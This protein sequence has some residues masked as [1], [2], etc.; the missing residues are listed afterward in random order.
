LVPL[1]LTKQNLILEQTMIEQLSAHGV[2]P[3]DLSPSL[4]KF[5][6]VKN[7]LARKDTESTITNES[8]VSLQP[9]SNR[10]SHESLH[11][12]NPEKFH[13]QETVDID[14]RWTLL[15]DLFLVLISDSVYDAR[16]RT[17][18]ECFGNCLEVSKLEII[19]FEEKV[20]NALEIEEASEQTWKET[21]IM[22][23]RRKKALRKKYMY[24][25][26]ATIGGGLVLGLSAGLLAPVIGAGLAA[27]F[28]T[29]GITGTSGFL[30]G[31]GGAAIVT[32]AGTA[33]GAKIGSSGMANR[34]DH[35]KTFEFRPLHNHKRV[36]L[37]IT[38]SGWMLGKED[39]VRLPFSTVDPI[40]GDL[41]SLY[42]EP[43]MLRSMGQTINIL[44]TEVLTQ[45][46]QQ[47]L[48]A[49]ILMALMSS[50]QLPMALSK[51]SYLLDN[52]WNVS[53]DR[54][55][56]SGLIL[57]DTLIKRNLGVRPVTLV[58]FSLGARVIYSCLVELAKKNA[59]GLIQDVFIFGAPVVVKSDQF[60][61]ARTVVHGRF[62]NGYS[63]KDWILGYLFRAT[64]GG[65]GRVAGLAPVAN[66]YGLE[67]F[68][69]TEFVDGH[70]GYRKAMPTLLSQLGWEVLSE[71]FA[72]IEDPDP[73]QHRVRQRQLIEEFDLARK[74]MEEE[75]KKEKKKKSFFGW[76]KKE[77]NWW[78]MYDKELEST[79]KAD[80][81]TPSAGLGGP[82]SSSSSVANADGVLFDVD[83]IKNELVDIV[84][85][86]NVP[87][88]QFEEYVPTQVANQPRK[89]ESDSIE[90]SFDPF[91]DDETERRGGTVAPNQPA[92]SRSSIDSRL[93]DSSS[94]VKAPQPLMSTRRGRP[95]V[96][97]AL[98]PSGSTPALVS[99]REPR[100]TV[101]SSST[102]NL[103]ST[104]LPLASPPTT[105]QVSLPLTMHPSNHNL[106][107]SPASTTSLP[108]IRTL[109]STPKRLSFT[110][111]RSSPSSFS[112]P[113]FDANTIG[114]Y[115]TRA[116]NETTQMATN[117][118]NSATT[119]K[120]IKP[121]GSN[122]TTTSSDGV[123]MTFEDDF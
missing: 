29:I 61:L 76:K 35:V 86:D 42:W 39:D 16:S 80:G 27:G 92:A 70:M 3:S 44:A 94:V 120:D 56:A 75:A 37:I 32:T 21:D 81:P 113:K 1:D 59:Y 109:P 34:M 15:C 66:V 58:G 9:S 51:L 119:R 110:H 106:S 93:S 55:W 57:A 102:T 13:N 121:A 85:S 53:L 41:Y 97:P 7:P 26:M 64:S 105:R 101:S 19:K 90:M 69:N 48:G 50:I 68:D 25:G 5:A 46:I 84:K 100:R 82:A 20:T 65:L 72:E 115:Q 28:T 79:H 74:Q 6:K 87:K 89:S 98:L 88:G 104:S 91:E 108:A 43:E 122:F 24:V 62:V 95:A 111:D 12:E 47:V 40:M 77:K 30:A 118:S 123:S 99:S 52:P 31:A 60:A 17:L 78:E 117:S 33:M 49:T 96:N 8:T 114:N 45:S 73:E 2:I 14:I 116:S 103:S 107:A 11:V 54:A 71:E 63:K 112:T 83:A 36:N 67:N 38:V 23:S 18:L 22:E 4:M 10:N